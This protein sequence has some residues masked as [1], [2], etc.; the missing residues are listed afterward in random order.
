VNLG[1]LSRHVGAR[2]EEIRACAGDEPGTVLVLVDA[3]PG[4]ATTRAIELV[5]AFRAEN[6]EWQGYRPERAAL[7]PGQWFVTSVD[8]LDRLRATGRGG[9][10]A[11][12]TPGVETHVRAYAVD[13][14]GAVRAFDVPR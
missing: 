1:A 9:E 8:E 13:E 2:V 7:R 10:L 3:R 6:P 4:A 11:R 12:F 5:R 14:S